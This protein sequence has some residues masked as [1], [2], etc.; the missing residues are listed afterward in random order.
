MKCV[1]CNQEKPIRA[2][3][4]CRSCYEKQLR[5]NNPEYAQKQKDA[6]KEWRK[7]NAEK[8][9][10]R[11]KDRWA[12]KE[13]VKHQS[14]YKWNKLLSSYDLNQEKYDALVANGCELCGSTS[15]GAYHLDHCHETGVFR[16]LLCSRCNNGLGML[17]DTIASL[18]KAIEYLK[19]TTFTTTPLPKDSYDSSR[20][21]TNSC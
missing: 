14:L 4:M 17:G 2:K 12:D 9:K 7:N 5:K 1:T 11:E 8:C 13:Y 16:G 19:R 20:R 15:A 18:E 6:Y 21:N 3:Q 10:Q